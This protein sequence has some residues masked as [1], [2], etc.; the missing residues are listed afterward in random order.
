MTGSEKNILV[1]ICCITFNHS[2]Y[3]K[4]CIE[5][6]LS[7]NCDFEYEIIINDD[8][9]TDGTVEILKEYA[10]LYP[11]RIRPIFHDENQWSKG[12]R[13]ILDTFVYPKASGKYIALC[14]GDDYWTDPYK[15][16]KQVDW[17]ERHPNY[18][19]CFHD[20]LRLSGETFLPYQPRYCNDRDA[21]TEDIIE[22][23]G[24]FIPTASIMY[25]SCFLPL[26]RVVVSQHI[27][28]YP[29]QIYLASVGKVRYMHA[30]MCVY[31]I[32]SNGSW[33]S[34]T[35]NSSREAFEDTCA[36]ELKLL[37]ELDEFTNK[38]Y[39]SAFKNR[40]YFH[41]YFYHMRFHEKKLALKC[42]FH[43]NPLKL[44]YPFTH[45]VRSLLHHK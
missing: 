44:K 37:K 19:M 41:L 4:E 9:S 24:L 39:S 43:I 17:L 14:E 23:G 31:R 25:R 16:Q 2:K 28:D 29:L 11:E 3:I 7:Q 36:K 21:S 45:F 13:K 10:N 27:G 12:I 40:K 42:L 30:P 5:G 8:C 26:P 32:G 18:S 15:L 22:K 6:F 34:R 38:R 1:S 35:Q 33:S 20:E